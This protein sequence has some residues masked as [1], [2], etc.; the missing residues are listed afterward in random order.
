M[1]RPEAL[2][3]ARPAEFSYR[4]SGGRPLPHS[5]DAGWIG[6]RTASFLLGIARLFADCQ[7]AAGADP[8]K[9]HCGLFTWILGA[10][11]GTRAFR[12]EIIRTR[13]SD[14]VGVPGSFRRRN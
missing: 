1:N 2:S 3:G 10:E 9:R 8:L 4:S 12:P 7:A 6:G 13:V 5:P 14:T 11:P